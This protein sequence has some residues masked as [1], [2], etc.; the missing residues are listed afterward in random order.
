MKPAIHFKRVVEPIKEICKKAP[1]YFNPKNIQDIVDKTLSLNK[2]LQ[3]QKN[4][5]NLGYEVSNVYSWDK[6][7]KETTDLI[8][9]IIS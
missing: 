5:I 7:F 3:K 1:I 6:C 8:L 4:H 9:N 2:D